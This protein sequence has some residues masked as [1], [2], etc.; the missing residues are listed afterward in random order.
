MDI[1]LAIVCAC[2][3]ANSIYDIVVAIR[4]SKYQKLWDK[5]KGNIIRIDP[6][7]TA[8]E[9]CARYVDFCEQNG[10]RVEF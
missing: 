6:A 3:V 10:C 1:F 4:N 7:I 8:Y 9:L 2:F 5:E